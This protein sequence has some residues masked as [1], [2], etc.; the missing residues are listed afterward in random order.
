MQIQKVVANIFK[1]SVKGTFLSS[2]LTIA[3]AALL[4]T[5]LYI[6]DNY[7]NPLTIISK[8]YF[9][10]RGFA[11]GI[12]IPIFVGAMTAVLVLV[13]KKINSQLAK[14]HPLKFLSL[15]MVAIFYVPISFVGALVIL[16]LGA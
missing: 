15:V 11:F 14:K 1:S 9:S 4:A 7:S 8:Y 16:Y 5:A 6:N 13:S 3:L 10:L 12:L 2:T